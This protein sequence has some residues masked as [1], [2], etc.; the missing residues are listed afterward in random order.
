MHASYAAR[1]QSA[2][3]PSGVKPLK[4][5]SGLTLFGHLVRAF[6]QRQVDAMAENAI[7]LHFGFV[8]LSAGKFQPFSSKANISGSCCFNCSRV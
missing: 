1:R 7:E 6:M 4:P 8:S 2:K 5:P 3:P